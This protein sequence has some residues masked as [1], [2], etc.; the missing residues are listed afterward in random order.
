MGRAQDWQKSIDEW[1]IRLTRILALASTM[2]RMNTR[3]VLRVIAALVAIGAGCSSSAS[4]RRCAEVPPTQLERLPNKLSGTGLFGANGATVGA[5]GVPDLGAGV[6]AF[7]PRFELW[8]DGATKRRFIALPE[9]TQIDTS[10][11]DAWRFPEGTKLWKEFTRD[12]VRVE[13]RWLAKI[14]SADED[15][16]AAAYLWD[17][18]GRD[19]TL[20]VDGVVDARGTAHDVPA[21]AQ[22]MACHGGTASRVLGVS[23]VQ[24][25]WST[26][27]DDLSLTGLRDAGRLTSAP[28]APIELPGDEP[29]RRGL[30]YLHANCAH[31][32]NQ[33][34]PLQRPGDPRCFDPRREIDLS[35][36]TDQLAR[37]EDTPVFRSCVDGALVPGDAEGSALFRRARGDL[38][39]FQARMPPLANDVPDP[40]VLPVLRAFIDAL[41]TTDNTP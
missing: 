19:A 37:I 40:S 23:A 38:E 25:P 14:G 34:R 36:R 6:V 27:D 7:T 15:W 12:G 4:Y 3:L 41:P 35:L 21:A 31:C 20:V 39:A 18:D 9:G 32:H 8:S 13:T 1:Q 33:H 10:D 29:T 22:C 24:L 5:P 16:L 11:M 17:D 2:R 28:E 26:S 30:G